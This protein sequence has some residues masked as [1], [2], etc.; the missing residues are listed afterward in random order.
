MK[1]SHNIRHITTLIP[2]KNKLNS[3]GIDCEILMH[4][5]KTIANSETYTGLVEVGSYCPVATPVNCV[6]LARRTV[7]VLA[8]IAPLRV[9]VLA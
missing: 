6:A 9:E 8:S 3:M 4:C 5:D 7:V 2:V 1:K